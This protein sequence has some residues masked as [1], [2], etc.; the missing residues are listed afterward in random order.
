MSLAEEYERAI[1]WTLPKNH[2]GLEDVQ[3]YNR[4]DIINHHD[5][6]YSMT[7]GHILVIN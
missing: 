7:K 4:R 3:D 2:I 1:I 5:I 6:E